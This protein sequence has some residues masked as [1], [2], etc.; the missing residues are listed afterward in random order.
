MQSEMT[1]SGFAA[2]A[3]ASGFAGVKLEGPA[4]VADH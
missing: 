1:I 4:S 2:A 3:E